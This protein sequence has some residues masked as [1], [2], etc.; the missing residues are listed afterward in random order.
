M[1]RHTVVFTLTHPVGSAAESDF[2]AA[3]RSLEKIPTV[4][5]FE[6]LRQVSTKNNFAY[7]LSMEFESAEAYEAYNV[8]PAHVTFV[9]D[10]WL[11]EV[12]EF[13]EIDYVPLDPEAE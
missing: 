2:L 13:M 11:H 1:I 8:D 9:K 12:T 6:C 7:G 10:R 3:A 4:R 5:Q